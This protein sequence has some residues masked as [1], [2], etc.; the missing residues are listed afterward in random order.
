MPLTFEKFNLAEALFRLAFGFVGP[1]EVSSLLG[2]YLVS[3]FDFL[4]HDSSSL[5]AAVSLNSHCRHRLE[6][7]SEVLKSTP[8]SHSQSSF[9][10]KDLN[11]A[12]FTSFGRF[13]QTDNFQSRVIQLE[14]LNQIVAND[15]RARL[16]QHPIFVAVAQFFGGRHDG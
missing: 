12:A 2:K 1:P 10:N 4:D 8:Q 7:P 11:L 13:S 15:L 3:L 9:I 5:P 14:I 6:F 16:R